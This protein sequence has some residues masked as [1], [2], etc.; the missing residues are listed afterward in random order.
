MRSVALCYSAAHDLALMA[1]HALFPR[2]FQWRRAL[3]TLDAVNHGVVHVMN[4]A[5]MFVFAAAGLFCAWLLA[6]GHDDRS[7]RVMLAGMAAFWAFRAILQPI[8]WAARHPASIALLAAF[9]LG[10]VAHLTAAL[11]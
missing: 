9:A 3:A 1:F 8:Y 6:T 7:A 10:A 5:L 11:Q 4:L 2:L